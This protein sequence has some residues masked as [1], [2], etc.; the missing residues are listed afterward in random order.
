MGEQKEL[1]V[2]DQERVKLS[3]Q[4][5][6]DEKDAEP[7]KFG[8]FAKAET[9]EGGNLV[10]VTVKALQTE[11]LKQRNLSLKYVNQ[12][13]AAYNALADANAKLPAARTR[14][15]AL[16]RQALANPRSAP[17]LQ[18]QI[19]QAN[20]QVVNL[21]TIKEQSFSAL[22]ISNK[23]IPTSFKAFA[24]KV[25]ITRILSDIHSQGEIEFQ[26][27]AKANRGVLTLLAADGQPE[28]EPVE[29]IIPPFSLPGRWFRISNRTVYQLFDNGSLTITDTMGRAPNRRGTWRHR[30]DQVTFQV[31]G[32]RE[33]Y[34][35]HED[36]MMES[37]TGSLYRFE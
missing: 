5:S 19:F 30:G 9:R 20:K 24:R 10:N 14:L 7:Y 11:I 28:A 34:N 15:D 4:F 17:G 2:D 16:K 6:N 12:N 21:Q 26:L 25:A 29:V 37:D 3:I 18:G 8:V 36:V 32:G 33:Q 31:D 13:I 1:H 23:N 27:F 22:T 35:L